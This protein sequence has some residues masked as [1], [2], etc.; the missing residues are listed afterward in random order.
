VAG[1]RTARLILAEPAATPS[2][3]PG[4]KANATHPSGSKGS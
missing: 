1:L 3:R 4:C 2:V